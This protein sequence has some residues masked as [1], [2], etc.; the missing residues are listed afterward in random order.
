[1]IMVWKT[2]YSKDVAFP[3]KGP[4]GLTWFPSKFQQ[5]S[6]VLKR[7]FKKMYMEVYIYKGTRMVKMI[8]MKKNNERGITL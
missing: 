3:P 6:C 4:I 5:D 2:Q 8:F 1:M 7:Y